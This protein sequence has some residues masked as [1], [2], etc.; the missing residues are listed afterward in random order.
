MMMGL[1]SW[2]SV[3][4]EDR[5]L[6]TTMHD[7][8]LAC[9]IEILT[10]MFGGKDKLSEATCHLMHLCRDSKEFWVQRELIQ[11][12][13]LFWT[14]E[15][16]ECIMVMLKHYLT[17]SPNVLATLKNSSYFKKFNWITTF[18]KKIFNTGVGVGGQ[19]Y[20]IYCYHRNRDGN[21]SNGDWWYQE[22]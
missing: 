21:E 2:F 3:F 12:N 6:C 19:C 7:N 10:T 15:K 9:L 20:Q 13:P 14:L 16:M 1:F 8:S 22:R 5:E 4:P 18:K 17:K 11:D